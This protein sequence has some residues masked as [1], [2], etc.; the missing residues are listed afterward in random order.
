MGP[1][2]RFCRTAGLL[3]LAGL[4]LIYAREF[5]LCSRFES[6]G[7]PL[8]DRFAKAVVQR[9]AWRLFGRTE[10]Y[11]CALPSKVLDSWQAEF[12]HRSEYWQLCYWNALQQGRRPAPANDWSDDIEAHLRALEYLEAGL[13]QGISDPQLYALAA[14]ESSW[15]AGH[16]ETGD[17]GGDGARVAKQRAALL[18]W[19][20]QVPD[21][22]APGYALCFLALESADFSAACQ[23]LAA[24]AQAED[25]ALPDCFP[26]SHFRAC[27]EHKSPFEYCISQV[28][29]GAM[30]DS[31]QPSSRVFNFQATRASGFE[32]WLV[33]HERLDALAVWY[34]LACRLGQ[35]G[36]ADFMPQFVA[37]NMIRRSLYGAMLREGLHSP[38][39]RR[40]LLSAMS[41]HSRLAMSLRGYAE[42]V[43]LQQRY[44][45]DWNIVGAARDWVYHPA[46]PPQ[47]TLEHYL[48]HLWLRASPDGLAFR[49]QLF[50]DIMFN[51]QHTA[52]E[53]RQLGQIDIGDPQLP[54]DWVDLPADQDGLPQWHP[55]GEMAKSM[56]GS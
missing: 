38:E 1:L 35:R 20:Q 45:E 10:Q 36:D 48:W 55:Q 49:A 51:Q 2:L 43:R 15:Q 31:A 46:A 19:Q 5:Y 37:L 18:R 56:Q 26:E 54:L 34:T 40:V 12:G 8:F 27:L 33:E 30:L 9:Q 53:F 42:T 47:P 28:F 29:S 21:A 13:A 7:N 32:S 25:Q 16:E 4:L 41:R 52:A 11:P 24:V 17:G 50:G 39:Q 3:I 22:A 23:H 6:S 14:L 44:F